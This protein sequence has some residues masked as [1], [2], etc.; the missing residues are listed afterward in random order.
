MVIAKPVGTG[1]HHQL[2]AWPAQPIPVVQKV[3]WLRKPGS[4]YTQRSL[5]LGA[6]TNLVTFPRYADYLGAVTRLDHPDSPPMETT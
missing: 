1:H 3:A 2:E 5:W 6:Y 4:T